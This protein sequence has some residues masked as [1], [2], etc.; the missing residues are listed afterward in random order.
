MRLF[1]LLGAM[2][3]FSACKTSRF[4]VTLDK[5]VP[6]EYNRF[7][8][9]FDS[10]RTQSLD[11]AL[12]HLIAQ[13]PQW[14]PLYSNQIIRT[15]DVNSAQ[16]PANVAEFLA[17]PEYEPITA[18]IKQQ[19]P[20]DSVISSQLTQ[21]FSYYYSYFPHD[22]IPSIYTYNGG[23]N[24]SIVIGE[25]FIG[26]GLDKY[27]VTQSRYYKQLGIDNYKIQ[28]MYPA[29]MPYDVLFA[30]ISD[31]HPTNF[32][33]TNVLTDILHQG[34]CMYLL[35]A[36]FPEAT[37]T[38][39]WGISSQKMDWLYSS[40]HSMWEYLIDKKLLF[41]TEYL[42]IRKFTGEGPFTAPFSKESP[43]RAAVWVGYRII[44]QYAEQTGATIPEI[45]EMTDFQKI[46]NKSR[47]NP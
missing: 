19:F 46:L 4:D 12:P 5:S 13:Y 29:Q 34:R 27:L 31:Q 25:G 3:L 18:N 23:F 11:S 30:H 22:T 32:T 20:N 41:D 15:G 28:R 39:L 45:F 33:P 40:E 16:F 47:Y 9:V 17:Y 8:L 36:C 26:V 35:N 10:L 42:T 38:A 24:Q 14:L 37:D 43:A 7:D 44:C 2:L 21:A 6:L 1:W